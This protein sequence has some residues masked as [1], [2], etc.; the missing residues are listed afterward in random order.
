MFA[1]FRQQ[2]IQAHRTVCRIF[3]KAYM[4]ESFSYSSNLLFC[5]QIM[6]STIAP[7]ASSDA[8]YGY[9]LVFSL[10]RYIVSVL[11]SCIPRDTSCWNCVAEWT[12]ITYIELEQSACAD[13]LWD[14]QRLKGGDTAVSGR[15]FMGSNGFLV[16]WISP[17]TRPQ[18]SFSIHTYRAFKS[19]RS[20]NSIGTTNRHVYAN[21]CHTG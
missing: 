14:D 11:R 8:A 12:D 6:A 13:G 7:T 15:S 18:K 21:I 20:I 4:T 19:C 10:Q 9:G 17:V 2:T 3:P 1:L 16:A 5:F